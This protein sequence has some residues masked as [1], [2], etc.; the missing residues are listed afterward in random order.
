[1][2]P[3]SI[4][5]A[6]VT[7]WN[8]SSTITLYFATDGFATLPTDTPA[9]TI[10]DGRLIQPAF[11]QRSAFG[12][13]AT[14][15]KTNANYGDLILANADGGLDAILGYGVDGRSLI[16]RHGL[17]GAP[18]PSAFTP[19]FAG[20]MAAII[21]DGSSGKD[22][23][24]I[25][26]A[27]QQQSLT[28]P[29]QPT[30]YA[31][32]NSLPN[33]LEGT[34][35]DLMGKP[36]PICLG[37]VLN[38]AP[39][40]VNTSK[41]IYQVNDS[42][43]ASLDA[44]YDRGEPLMAGGTY[45]TVT[46]LQD[47]AQEPAPGT[48]KVYLAGG[49]FRL[50][51]TPA[52]TVTADVSEGA[53]TADRTTAQLFVR[54]LERL[55]LTTGAWSASDIT[56]LDAA[57]NAVCGYWTASV[58]N[59]SDVLDLIAQSP[60]AWWGADAT[61]VIRIQQLALPTGSP[62][63]SFVQDDCLQPL[64]LLLSNDPADGL[65]SYQSIVQYGQNYTVQSV[66]FVDATLS[67]RAR[68]IATTSTTI[69][70]RVAVADPYPQ[71]ANSATIAYQD[72]GS[73]GVSPATGQTVTPDTT[74]T[75]IAGSYVDFTITLPTFGTNARVT[76]TATASNRQAAS[77]AVDVPMSGG[78]KAVTYSNTAPSSP[79]TND[80]WLDTSVNPNVWNRWNGSAW[81]PATP[82]TAAQITYTGTGTPTVDSLKPAEVGAEQTTGKSLTVLTNRTADNIGYTSGA[83]G[84]TVDSL[85]PAQAQATGDGFQILSNPDFLGSVNPF[86]VYDNSGSGKV[87][88]SL[89]AD[90]TIPNSSGVYLAITVASGAVY[91]VTP[92]P[93]WGG[94]AAAIPLDSGSFQADTYHKSSTILWRVRASIPVGMSIGWHSNTTGDQGSATWLTS[95]AGTGNYEDY[96]LQ[97][98]IGTTSA[99]HAFLQTGYFSL[100]GTGS[101]TLPLTWF[102]ALCSATC[103]THP[104]GRGVREVDPSQRAII[105]L[106]QA[107]HN[108]T[109]SQLSGRTADQITYTSGGTPT[110]D[111]LKP[112][113]A[114]AD[115]TTGKSIDI[116]VDGSTYARVK[117]TELSSGQVAQAHDTVE[118]KTMTIN[119]ARREAIMYGQ[120]L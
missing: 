39:P 81:V 99:V 75:E 120:V 119:Q 12:P 33:G 101:E 60:L 94:F 46:D 76:F 51:S 52:G 72:Q 34:T 13:Q 92:T 16:V 114:S 111:S 36:K 115:A 28:I 90:S 68:L 31:G 23:V 116:L 98:V 26:I 80:L 105:D 29:L 9:N 3:P 20:T 83:G 65:P 45:A 69:T 88:H 67:V 93:E 19:V 97:Q 59:G 102:V 82:T 61:G 89:V 96:V 62:V 56:A 113:E 35:S 21:A 44:V 17:V 4:Y 78:A 30:L 117:A 6:E 74:L 14:S 47:D 107:H 73:G 49:Y 118:S 71:G 57:N 54:V 70:V 27:D 58:V 42:A 91:G 2:T 85:R 37:S 66:D 95:T 64:A 24:T 25:K 7:A 11:L 63:R 109:L 22:A 8:G 110:V 50:G 41:L 103:I 53:T 106:S 38:I 84:G 77:D 18:Y 87:T 40:C 32:T 48:Y 108:K 100:V 104:G 55:G 112:A 43:I 5:V 15:G 79:A 1:M 10:V 86:S